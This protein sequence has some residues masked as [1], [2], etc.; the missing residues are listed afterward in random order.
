MATE[1]STRIG[2]IADTLRAKCAQI[3]G[4]ANKLNDLADAK[5]DITGDKA[6]VGSQNNTRLA[7]A[8][9]IAKLSAAENWTK[10]ELKA[11][12]DTAKERSN[13]KGDPGADK[14]TDKSLDVFISEMNT[15]AAPE[16]RDHF[17]TIADACL[18]AWEDENAQEKSLPA[19][20]HAFSS[21]IWHLTVTIAR[22]VKD[23]K[24]TVHGPYDVIEYCAANDP[25]QDAK[26][27]IDKLAVMCKSLNEYYGVFEH[28]DLLGA[29]AD[30]GAITED[31]L[32]AVRRGVEIPPEITPPLPKPAVRA[33]QPVEGGGSTPPTTPPPEAPVDSLLAPA[34]GV[35][36]P[37]ADFENLTDVAKPAHLEM[38][39]Q[40]A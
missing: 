16:V 7:V 3:S 21:R 9:E 38:L 12:A 34:E 6:H 37:M 36:D 28:E 13:V 39:A 15:C 10:G 22:R 26:K 25:A 35:Y 24:L 17:A 5:L 31:M 40:A 33:L 4:D 1:K 32:K 18:K 27:I 14:R 20:V 8:K 29:A 30:L 19:P 23:G 2:A 11:A